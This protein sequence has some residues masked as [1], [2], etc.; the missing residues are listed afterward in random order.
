MQVGEIEDRP[1]FRAIPGEGESIYVPRENA[2]MIRR[3]KI[4]DVEFVAKAD[5]IPRV[6]KVILEK[7]PFGKL[8]RMRT[9]KRHVVSLQQTVGRGEK[10]RRGEGEKR[11]R[12]T[13]NRLRSCPPSPLLPFSLPRRVFR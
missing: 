2:E 6:V 5:D 3:A 8:V 12:E 13:A 1:L 9:R 4:L 10:G 7:Y 11:R